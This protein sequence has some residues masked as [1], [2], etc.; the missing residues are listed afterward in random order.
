[1]SNEST[2]LEFSGLTPPFDPSVPYRLPLLPPKSKLDN[3]LYTPLLIKARTALAHLDGLSSRTKNPLLLISPAITRESVASS[4]IENIHT[5]IVEVLR[6]DLLP[7]SEQSGVDKE[8]LRYRDAVLLGA[9]ELKKLPISSRLVLDVFKKLM[10]NQGGEYRKS[11]NKIENSTTKQPIYTPPSAEQLPG[12]ISNWEKFANSEDD[13]IDPLIR[14]IVGHYQFEAIHPFNDGNGRTGRIL[15]ILQLL[16]YGL[17]THPILFISA[18][19]L[20]ERPE[21]YRTLRQITATGSWDDYIIFMLNA[22]HTQAEATK[23]IIGSIDKLHEKTREQVK[24]ELPKIYTADLIDHLFTFPVTT[25]TNMAE[26]LGITYQ[27][28]SKYLKSLEALNIL[29][30]KKH[31]T[32]NFFMNH[33][34]LTITKE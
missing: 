22:F 15:M 27:T 32:Y 34:L 8:V 28:A 19:I 6:A 21:Y 33:K 18:Y 5:T 7:E 14:C 11:Q 13:S 10:P 3:P 25:P 1:M 9:K 29:K 17:L 12:L 2:Q 23:K 24:D 20:K 16:Q 31:G 26:E 30:S 4:G